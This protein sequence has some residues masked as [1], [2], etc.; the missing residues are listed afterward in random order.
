M[1]GVIS[2][3]GSA[4]KSKNRGASNN[5][6][7]AKALIQLSSLN[8]GYVPWTSSSMKPQA[9]VHILNEIVVNKKKQVLEL[10]MGVTTT[11]IAA[12]IKEGID[13]QLISIDHD[14][15]WIDICKK[16]LHLRNLVSS[17][18]TF[19]HA[20]LTENQFFGGFGGWYDM[21]NLLAIPSFKPDLL[22]IDGPPAWRKDIENARVP[23]FE[24]LSQKLSRD[25]TV[26]IDD[27]LR[28]GESRLVNLFESDSEWDLVVKDEGA[29]VAILRRV[30][31][32]SYNPF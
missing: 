3:V 31:T 16:Q 30:G 10:G 17:S 12:L 26:F 1:R 2:T 7:E 27:Y 29:N 20:P 28:P 23:V 24:A 4:V 19:I 22:I 8:T 5:C 13:T 21:Q 6:R 15:E 9:V 14:A 11:C 25:A 18:H 32:N